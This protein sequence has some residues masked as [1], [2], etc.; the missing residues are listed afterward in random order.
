MILIVHA[1]RVGPE[2]GQ[3]IM[4]QDMG[5]EPGQGMVRELVQRTVRVLQLILSEHGTVG[6]IATITRS[7]KKRELELLQTPRKRIEGQ[8]QI[9]RNKS[10]EVMS[11]VQKMPGEPRSTGAKETRNMRL[12][13]N[14]VCVGTPPMAKVAHTVRRCGRHETRQYST[15]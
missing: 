8:K 13:A 4:E 11:G 3:G 2:P 6:M 10:V 7:V 12:R 9:T 5:R 1:G 14:K 15:E